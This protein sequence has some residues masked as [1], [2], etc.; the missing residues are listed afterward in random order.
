M[1]SLG[2][3]H[4]KNLSFRVLS[5]IAF[6]PKRLSTLGISF[7][8]RSWAFKPLLTPTPLLL[9]KIQ[10]SRVEARSRAQKN[11]PRRN[12][13]CSPPPTHAETDF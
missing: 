5:I 4:N 13:L 3:P 8:H 1:G 12:L 6:E 7:D 2:I 10:D 11:I 9:N